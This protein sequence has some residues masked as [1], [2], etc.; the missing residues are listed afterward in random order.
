MEHKTIM[1]IRLP[2]F[3]TGSPVSRLFFRVCVVV[4]GLGLWAGVVLAESLHE[5][6]LAEHK[7]GDLTQA[8]ALYK[9][10][11]AQ[12]KD[13]PVLRMDYGD[14]LML[15]QRFSEARQHYQAA[16][17]IAPK[18]ATAHTNLGLVHEA[19]GDLDK[20]KKEHQQA[21][22]IDPN[23]PQAHL[24]LGHVLEM[25]GLLNEAKEEYRK[26][27]LINMNYL[28]GYESLAQ[29]LTKTGEY[30]ASAETYEK[31]LSIDPGSAAIHN[32]LAHAYYKMGDY[33]KAVKEL[34]KTL[35][36]DPG[37]E[38]IRKNLAYLLEKAKGQVE[39]TVSDQSV[40]AA[41]P[42]AEPVAAQDVSEQALAETLLA[43][44][45]ASIPEPE[46]V[47]T[48]PAPAGEPPVAATPAEAEEEIAAAPEEEDT[49]LN[50][51]SNAERA[52]MHGH[53]RTGDLPRKNK[54][55]KE[56][57]G[58]Q[59]VET[60]HETPTPAVAGASREPAREKARGASRAPSH[61]FATQDMPLDVLKARLYAVQ[62][63]RGKTLGIEAAE[64]ITAKLLSA[65]NGLGILDVELAEGVPNP[66]AD[67]EVDLVLTPTLSRYGL[68]SGA[69]S[70]LLGL[71]ETQTTTAEVVLD[72]VVV[73]RHNRQIHTR[74]NIAG[75]ETSAGF[76]LFQEENALLA[77]ASQSAAAQAASAV[78]T[79]VLSLSK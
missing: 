42:S 75:R 74:S 49:V 65:L 69:K 19:L 2:G 73:D 6:A 63:L 25:M 45:K 44:E 14:L 41:A 53:I 17:A 61:G 68:S 59:G 8:E 67:R 56:T 3:L 38:V 77:Q 54:K 70:A 58:A 57:E 66:A 37:N 72:I 28:L 36:L 23:H 51:I 29:V 16:I 24:N 1:D 26:S 30:K 31:A 43:L 55:A 40:A 5:R 13:N 21:L 52:R 46:A 27:V 35:E 12:D 78:R 47:A 71:R 60:A 7:K 4:M 62:G 22:T 76:L 9:Q 15:Q 11:V 48:P 50:P 34:E 32:N 33:E 18:N 64:D 10:A 79:L 20:A 39:A